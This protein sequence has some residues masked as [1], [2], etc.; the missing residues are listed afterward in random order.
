MAR[1]LRNFPNPF[2][3]RTTVEFALSHDATASLRVYD[4]RGRL[5][6]T[7][8]ES[9]VAAGKHSVTWDGRND[10]GVTVVSGV[11]FLRL[12]AGDQYLSRTVNLLK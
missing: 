5:V 10:Q 8:L 2:N 9:Y 1:L 11:Y 6:R 4:A 3:P 12:Q 7:L